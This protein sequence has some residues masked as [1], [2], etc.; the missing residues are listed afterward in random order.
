MTT[1]TPEDSA[2]ALTDDDLVAYVTAVG[3]EDVTYAKQCLAEANAAVAA[4]LT[5]GN[6]YKVPQ[7]VVNRAVLEVGADLYYR[8]RTRNGVAE[9]GGGM[10]EAPLAIRVN[11]DPLAAAYPILRP[12]MPA[13]GLG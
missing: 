2:P 10:G 4:F 6:P 1:P 8:K 11:R 7:A 9:F 5:A 3:D 13:W 12:H